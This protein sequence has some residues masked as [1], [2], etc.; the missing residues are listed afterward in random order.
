MP[1]A[2]A[3]GWCGISRSLLR[4][5]SAWDPHHETCSLAGRAVHGD[6]AVEGVHAV[7]DVG[8]ALAAWRARSPAPA[9][10]AARPRRPARRPAR[11]VTAAR[12]GF[13]GPGHAT[14]PARPR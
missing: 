3:P 1:P 4:S 9:A 13:R 6:L 5:L 12:G 14:R 8:Q 7:G 10:E 2:A 11:L